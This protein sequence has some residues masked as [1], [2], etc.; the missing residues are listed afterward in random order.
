[1]NIPGYVGNTLTLV[2]AAMKTASE[3]AWTPAHS[4]YSA[5]FESLDQRL[6]TFRTGPGNAFCSHYWR[7]RW[8]RQQQSTD[9][10]LPGLRSRPQ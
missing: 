9:T 8:Q 4:A 1:M 6:Q 3:C 2:H 10:L 5:V 7:I